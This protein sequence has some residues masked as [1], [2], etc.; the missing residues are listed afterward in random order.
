MRLPLQAI[1]PYFA[2]FPEEFARKQIL[3]YSAEG[4]WVYDPFS[5]RGT[6]ILEALLLGRNAAASDINPVAVCISKA[7]AFRPQKT[8][9]LK[10]IDELEA[11]FKEE[12]IETWDRARIALPPFFKRAFYAST[13]HEL[14]FLKKSLNWKNKHADCFITALIL[15]SLHGEM[16][17]SHAYFSNQMPRT[18]CLKP[19]Y[20]LRYWRER[21]LFPRKRRVFEMLREKTE[22]R[23][24]G[25]PSYSCG[26]VKKADA[27]KASGSF[28]YLKKAVSLV[29]TSPPYL[30][31]TRYEEDQWLRLWF[32]GGKPWP[33]YGSISKDDRH[34]SSDRYWRFLEEAW[35]G[36]APLLKSHATFVIRIGASGLSEAEVAGQLLRS[37]KSVFPVVALLKK[38]RRSKIVG[39]QT[40]N[41]LPSSKGCIYELDFVIEVRSRN[42]R[43][44]R[45]D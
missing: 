5:G 24:K 19:E 11:G 17:K 39:R 7:K 8:R 30:N 32:L 34:H 2:M 43:A 9:I 21:N 41:F 1:C 42:R 35:R 28:A 29:L 22:Y 37:F 20:S 4:D 23:L 33:T 13:L 40:S 27:R 3:A 12:D 38:P 14:L 16:D 36:I 44:T 45:T 25:L 6:A 15:G 31:V 18:I 10:R 26:T